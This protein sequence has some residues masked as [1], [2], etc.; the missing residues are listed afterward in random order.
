MTCYVPA[1]LLRSKELNCQLQVAFEQLHGLFGKL[2]CLPQLADLA[3]L[4]Q[5][6]QD[7][8]TGTLSPD[9]VRC[10]SPFSEQLLSGVLQ[11]L[12]WV[13]EVPQQHPGQ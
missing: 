3:T 1:T 9:Q 5:A 11:L 8:S 12:Q 7:S 13:N 6:L 4:S 10:R 2:E